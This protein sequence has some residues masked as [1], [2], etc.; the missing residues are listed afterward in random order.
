F[1]KEA[2]EVFSEFAKK[3]QRN[4]PGKSLEHFIAGVFRK[5]P[6]VLSV[7]ENGSGFK[8]DYGA[9]L[10]VSYKNDIADFGSEELMVVQIKSY[11][12]EIWNTQA[13]DQ[14]K[15]ALSYFGASS[16]LIIT[17]AKSTTAIEEAV[18]SLSNETGKPVYV[19]A[20]EDLAR[21]VLT[22]GMDLI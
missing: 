17:T 5:V 3:I 19:L 2:N 18:S 13:A 4:Y 7:K 1:V 6:G 16:G 14:I 8:S 9:D 11:E 10:I 15:T 21:F 22:Y 12:G 20:G